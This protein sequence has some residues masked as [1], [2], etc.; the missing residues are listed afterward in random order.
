MLNL[1]IFKP[2]PPSLW[3]EFSSAMIQQ[4]SGK[5]PR[6]D[7]GMPYSLTDVGVELRRLAEEMPFKTL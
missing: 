7:L 2:N 1:E 3:G 5:V 6:R 4:V